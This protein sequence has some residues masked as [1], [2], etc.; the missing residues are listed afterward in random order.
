[1]NSG[2]KML[3]GLLTGAAVG[4]VAG[5]LFAPASG[6][7]TRSKLKN[8]VSEVEDDLKKAAKKIEE[9]ESKLAKKLKR[10]LKL[11]EAA[12]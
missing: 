6:E 3:F 2:S 1:M 8:K 4:Y 7:E 5:V 10:E 9:L 11:D 12:N